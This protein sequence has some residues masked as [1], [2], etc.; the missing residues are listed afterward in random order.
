MSP[1]PFSHD[2]CK[3]FPIFKDAILDKDWNPTQLCLAT[4]LGVIILCFFFSLL[5]GNYSQVDK[6]WSIV[7]FVYAWLVVSDERTLLMA[8]V[9]TIWGCRLTWNFNRRGGYTW[10]PWEGD[11]DYRWQYLQ[12]GFLVTVLTNRVAWQLFNV[13]FIC[14]YQNIL[15]LLV[16]SPSIV[17]HH[18]SSFCG[19][20]PLNAYDYSAAAL[21]LFFVVVET[22]ADNEQ[23]AFQTEKYRLKDA[24]E[25]LKGEFAD[26]FKQSGLFAIVRKPNYAAEQSIWISYYVFSVGAVHGEQILNWCAIGFVLLCLL[27]QGSGQMTESISISKYPKY[28]EYQRTTP[29]Y[30]P[31]PLQF[32]K[33]KDK[34]S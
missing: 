27:F 16:A 29:L 33:P 8:V 22:L 19:V 10:P 21:I 28:K 13:F 5:N 26:G 3:I 23:Y 1:S 6:I 32:F 9:A 25:K 18:V 11:E 34:T 20:A 4:C 7:P 31:N 12:D 17:A 24:G 30:I 14:I 2:E 15:L